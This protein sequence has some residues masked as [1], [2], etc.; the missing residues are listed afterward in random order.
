MNPADNLFLIGPMG[1]GKS[2]IGRRLAAHFGLRFVDLDHE[3]E[4]RTGADIP[5]IFELEGEAGFRRRERE[6]L[7]EC[8]A[9]SG[10]VLACGGG[11]VLDADNRRDLAAHGFVVYLET[12]VEQ[13]LQRLERDR[14]RPLLAAPDRQQRLQALAVQ[15]N[16]LYAEIADL[17]VSSHD[18]S[19][20]HAAARIAALIETVWQPLR[21]L[22]A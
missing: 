12:D 3:I 20:A 18:E 13:Q 7:A 17:T 15:R 1:A 14:H 22:H 4:S 8:S 6:L 11:V 19:A 10:I 16:P 9:L 5:L 21:T 2:S